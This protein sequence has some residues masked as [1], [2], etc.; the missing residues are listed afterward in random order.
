MDGIELQT[1]Q[2]NTNEMPVKE[3]DGNIQVKTSDFK[4]N[5]K[6]CFG[7]VL[8]CIDYISDVSILIKLLLNGHWKLFLI[9]LVIDLIIGPITALQMYSKGYGLKKSL[10]LIIHPVNIIRQSFLTLKSSE[11]S[12]SHKQIFLIGKE[13]QGLLEAPLQI[14]FTMT[15]IANN[16]LQSPWSED[17]TGC[18]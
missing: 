17:I 16:I 13:L 14:I 15:L 11:N 1:E 8:M 2:D 12:E 4:E 7:V 6:V 3:E 10:T 18:G 5:M 9:G